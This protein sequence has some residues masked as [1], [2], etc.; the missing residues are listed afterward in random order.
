MATDTTKRKRSRRKNA[1]PDGTMS[2]VEHLQELRAR[3]IKS[4]IFLTLGAIM[5]Y[6]WYQQSF[7][8]IDSLGDILRG[9]YCSL[10]AERR[11]ALT[12]D[13]ECRLIATSP[14]E[15]F[16]LRLKIGAMAG[17]VFSS[18]IWLYQLWAFITPGLHKK[19]RGWTF[20]FVSVAVALFVAGAVLA[21]AVV[22]YGL[23][24]LLSIGDNTQIAALSGGQ[25]F[26]F[27]LAL[28]MIFGVSFEVPLIIAALNLAGLVSYELIKDKRRIIVVSLFIF[29]AVMT[30]G[31]DP[32]SM[33]VLAIALVALVELAIQFTRIND[34]RRAKQRP[35]WMDLDDE[36][37]SPL[38]APGETPAASWVPAAPTP[39]EQPQ[40]I[41]PSDNYF[42]DIT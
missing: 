30:P 14:F 6:V 34:K 40:P 4:L 22:S 32:F 39:V 11:A 12:L 10:P 26:N 9:P 21:Y 19:E 38:E 15:M 29:A 17:I 7:G 35:E 25:Y 18:P 31:Q 27:V 8:P 23:D 20:A 37:A 3:V 5:G 24:F 41:P 33:F 2:L 36:A 42:D 1:N 13:G 16:L 28:L